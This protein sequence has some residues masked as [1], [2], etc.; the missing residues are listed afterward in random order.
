MPLSSNFYWE[1]LLSLNEGHLL[2]KR[3]TTWFNFSKYDDDISTRSFLYCFCARDWRV[4]WGMGFT[5]PQPLLKRQNSIVPKEFSLQMKNNWKFIWSSPIFRCISVSFFMQIELW[6]TFYTL[7]SKLWRWL[8]QR[9][10]RGHGLSGFTRRIFW[11]HQ[12][13]L[14]HLHFPKP[15]S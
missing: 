6:H 1:C 5:K 3:Q 13:H 12:N 9:E 4:L 11:V 15:L 8:W 2:L 14:Y 7:N 10:R